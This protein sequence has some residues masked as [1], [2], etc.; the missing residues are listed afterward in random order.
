ME[1]SRLIRKLREERLVKAIEIERVSRAIADSRRNPDFYVSHATLADIEGGSIPSIF[2]IFSLA[3]CLKLPYEQLLLVFG[4]DPRQ[5]EQY[6]G[7]EDPAQTNLEQLDLR[8]QTT[9][10]ELHFDRRVNVKE[11]S[12]LDTDLPETALVPP[13]LRK[14]LDPGRFRYALVGLEDD[15]MKEIIP[16]G[17]L[18]EVDREQNKVETFAW[19]TLVQR[20]IYLV[21]HDLGYSCRWCQQDRNEL[22]LLPHPASRFP[23]TRFRTPSQASVIGRI[24]HAWLAL[25]TP[26]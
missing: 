24:L 7:P 8:P 5:V 9:R 12:L 21:L 6:A 3:V 1:S 22:I 10:F 11:T 14:R 20:P 15:S 18:V 16:P 25:A 23:V 4:V 13:S 2:K 26:Q 17:S 19:T